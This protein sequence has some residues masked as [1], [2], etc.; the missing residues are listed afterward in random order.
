MVRV[1]IE[2][3]DKKVELVLQYYVEIVKIHVLSENFSI[4]GNL[5]V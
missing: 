4:A 3:S 1:T 5:P 2:S